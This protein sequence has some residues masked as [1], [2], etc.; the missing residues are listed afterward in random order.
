M[1]DLS[2][3]VKVSVLKWPKRIVDSEKIEEDMFV[4]QMLICNAEFMEE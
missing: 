3:Y 2:D 1:E 4:R